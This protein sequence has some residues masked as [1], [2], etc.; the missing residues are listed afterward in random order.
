MKN[1]LE[2]HDGNNIIGSCFTLIE[3]LVV[4]AI[5]T[6]LAGMLLP[7]LNKARDK[8]R[9]ASCVS[10]LKQ[11]NTG[12][13]QYASDNMEYF[14]GANG[15]I[16][17]SELNPATAPI[18]EDPTF[19]ATSSKNYDSWPNKIYYYIGNKKTYVCA[20]GSKI[21]AGATNYGMPGGKNK[22]QTKEMLFVY[23]RKVSKLKRPAD[24][25]SMSEKISPGGASPFILL[26][27]DYCMEL[28]HNNGANVLSV[29]GHVQWWKGDTSNITGWKEGKATNNWNKHVDERAFINWNK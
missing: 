7:A 18:P 15:D 1:S 9:Q 27:G 29:D 6:I 26:S 14:P 8:A 16:K 3:L 20:A 17:A 22:D 5:I 11:M 28:P 4:I 21:F 2:K 24:T 23:A 10:N 12:L 25:M 19:M 13:V